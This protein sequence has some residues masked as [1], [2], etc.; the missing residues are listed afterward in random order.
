MPAQTFRTAIM[1]QHAERP[2]LPDGLVC[3]SV[4]P[5]RLSMLKVCTA[6]VTAH[7][8][9][10]NQSSQLKTNV[11]RIQCCADGPCR[12]LRRI[13]VMTGNLGGQ[14]LSSAHYHASANHR[15]KSLPLPHASGCLRCSRC[16]SVCQSRRRWKHRAAGWGFC[17][18]CQPPACRA[19]LLCRH[20]LPLLPWQCQ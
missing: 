14:D 11:L 19:Q 10:C 2:N 6:A 3:R 13:T 18:H 20:R 16:V 5:L 8:L 15:Q 12:L 7:L 4:L 17:W 9:E 1:A